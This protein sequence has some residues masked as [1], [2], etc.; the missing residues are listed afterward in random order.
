[1]EFMFMCPLDLHCE[2]PRYLHYLQPPICNHIV[3]ILSDGKQDG[4]DLPSLVVVAAA[5]VLYLQLSRLSMSSR[6]LAMVLKRSQKRLEKP[7]SL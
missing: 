2:K 1:M 3:I 6:T 4:R 5:A 7:H